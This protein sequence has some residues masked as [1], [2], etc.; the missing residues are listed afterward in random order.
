MFLFDNLYIQSSNTRWLSDFTSNLEF[1]FIAR[2]LERF[3]SFNLLVR[4]SELYLA[5]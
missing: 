5:Q 1:S 4:V 2:P 3:K